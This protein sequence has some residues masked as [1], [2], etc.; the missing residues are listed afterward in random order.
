MGNNVNLISFANF[1][2]NDIDN[3]QQFGITIES[4]GE[5][6]KDLIFGA[7]MEVKEGLKQFHGR[8]YIVE[9][10][11]MLLANE[12]TPIEISSIAEVSEEIDEESDHPMM[13]F[14]LKYRN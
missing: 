9:I 10:L 13:L 12:T 2:E 14:K 8:N 3:L 1:N 5:F 7:S 4:N 11:T 6:D